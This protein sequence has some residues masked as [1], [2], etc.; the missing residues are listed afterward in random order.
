MEWPRFLENADEIADYVEETSEEEAHLALVRE[1]FKDCRAELRK[2]SVNS[3][4]ECLD[5]EAID[6]VKLRIASTIQSDV[7][8]PILVE[9][10][11]IWDGQCRLIAAQKQ[12]SDSIW[13][14]CIQNQSLN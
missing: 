12:G 3:L 10:N 8:N 2:I 14:Y 9:G 7:S 5:L 11:V 6:P 13:A 1:I 4:I